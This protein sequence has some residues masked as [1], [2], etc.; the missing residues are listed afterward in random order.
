D[1]CERDA[2]RSKQIGDDL[3]DKTRKGANEG[4]EAVGEFSD[5]AR[6][7]F[8]EITSSFTGDMDSIVDLAQG[9]FGGLAGTLTGPLGLAFGGLA[10]AGGLFYNQWKEASE[11]TKAVISGM[12]E[13]MLESGAEYLSRDAI[14]ERVSSIVTGAED[15]VVSYQELQQQAEVSGASVQ[16]LLLAWAGDQD[17]IN[18]VLDTTNDKLAETSQKWRDGKIE[19]DEY[20]GTRYQLT[21]L[22]D[23]IGD[24]SE[25]LGIA[26][27][28][29]RTTREAMNRLA[30]TRVDIPIDANP[31]P[32]YAQ[33]D[34]LGRVI[35]SN[36]PVI[37][38]RADTSEAER[39]VQQFLARPRRMTIS[40]SI[41]TRVM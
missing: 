37:P 28:G 24:V 10:A 5:E 32:A 17:A 26:A 40:S 3:G 13:D 36:H 21:D 11:K 38:V 39:Q 31:R 30:Q 8:G 23:R 6:Q 7:N 16:D 4:S 25:N 2:R 14:Q 22:Q 33:L 20:N 15:A 27:D 34:N 41:G 12:Y 9:T 1:G 19:V 29:A 18:R 35:G